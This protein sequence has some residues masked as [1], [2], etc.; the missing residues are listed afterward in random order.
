M[1]WQAEGLVLGV[2]PFGESSLRLSLITAQ[3]GR[4]S[5][6]VRGGRKAK[7]WLETGNLVNAVWKARLEEQ[8]GTFVCEPL[9]QY[10][11]GLLSKP[12]P[13]LALSS[14]AA[15]LELGLPERD[16]HPELFSASLSLIENLSQP[17][18]EIAYIAWELILLEQL[19]FGLDLSCCAA[20]GVNDGLGYVSPKSG[21]AV[22]WSA[23]EAYKDKLLPLPGFLVGLGLHSLSEII[24][25]LNLTGYFLGKALGDLPPA[26]KRL[27]IGLAKR[28]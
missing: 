17:G 14:W 23:G 27:A 6:L 19:G 11:A 22:S 1:E 26:R 24:P 9:R 15:L 5:G 16:S 4:H 25:A 2:H 21:R 28:V 12:L 3:Q 10:S 7:A 18:W 13:L 8:L 20:T